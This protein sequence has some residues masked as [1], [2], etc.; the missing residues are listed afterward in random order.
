MIFFFSVVCLHRSWCIFFSFSVH[1]LLPTHGYWPVVSLKTVA[2]TRGELYQ[3]IVLYL[4]YE[5]VFL[6]G[7]S[8]ISTC[9]LYPNSSLSKKT[10]SYLFIPLLSVT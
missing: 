1:G 8:C 9:L 6:V 4:I 2:S 3:D 7:E 5:C 10:W